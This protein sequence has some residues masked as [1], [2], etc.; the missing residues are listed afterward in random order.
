MDIYSILTD[1]TKLRKM[2]PW[3]W[4]DGAFHVFL[5]AFSSGANPWTCVHS[6]QGSSTSKKVILLRSYQ[7]WRNQCFPDFCWKAKQFLDTQI[8][9]FNE[10][11]TLE[12]SADNRVHR[13]YDYHLQK[14]GIVTWVEKKPTKE[15]AKHF[16]S[17]ERIK[18]KES[19]IIEKTFTTGSSFLLFFSSIYFPFHHFAAFLQPWFVSICIS[20][21]S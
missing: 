16:Q 21:F 1:R 18:I 19:Q 17:Y 12:W 4:T 8:Q 5:T 10:T 2:S 14:D 9:S 11:T 13:P 15:N 20:S 7:G 6:S 3:F